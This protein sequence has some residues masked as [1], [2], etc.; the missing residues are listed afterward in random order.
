MKYL[1]T[2][3]ASDSLSFT[4]A[5]LEGLSRDG[6]LFV[7][8][9]L[10]DF[11]DHL[12]QFKT[13]SY[14]DLA[15][16]L[17]HPFI[18]GEFSD[19]DL[20]KLVG[21]SY[22]TFSHPNITPLT[23][24]DGFSILELYHGPTY[25]FKDVALQFLAKLFEKILQKEKRQLNILGAT[26]G[27]TGSAAIYGVRGKR[28]INIFMLHPKGKISAIQEKQM[29]SV[30]DENVINI[31]IQGTFDDGQ[32]IIKEIFSD[33][34]F[35]DQ[36]K[37][38]TVNSINWARVMAQVVYY[39]YSAFR[40]WNKY[41]ETPLYFSVPTGNF[42]NIYA[43]YLAGQMGLPIKKLIL[44]TNE[45][46]ILYRTLTTGVYEIQ[47]VFTSLSPAMDIQVASNFERFLFDLLGKDGNEVK[48]KMTALKESGQFKLSTSQLKRARTYF[49]PM[50]VDS[51]QTIN[52]IREHAEH[53]LFI[54]PHTA[55]GV[56]A[57]NESD[58]EN[59]ICLSPAHPAKFKDTVEQAC[60]K[61][62]PIPKAIEALNHKETK[63]LAAPPNQEEIKR[64]IKNWGYFT[65]ARE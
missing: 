42:G 14:Q 65:N 13:L 46:D 52:C 38:G 12:K 4:N 29:T 40:L 59:V 64:I 61:T 51:E 1:S 7:P 26:S 18:D 9:T 8:E 54:D 49:L 35:K 62:F 58:Y 3:E 21:E 11:S 57:A 47:D 63:Y 36:Y 39:F 37:L 34:E 5:V 27:D 17:F 60:H 6:G 25:A 16:Q 10:P 2:R 24:H 28:G 22:S 32:R 48:G 53:G 43:G 15:F 33:L 45:N 50:R 20:R 31:A 56:V 19:T 41:P 55:T 23:F 30:L 44:A